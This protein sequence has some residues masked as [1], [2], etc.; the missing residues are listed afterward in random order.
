MATSCCS[1]QAL[2]RGKA[3]LGSASSGVRDCRG[4]RPSHLGTSQ[5]AKVFDGRREGESN[6]GQLCPASSGIGDRCKAVDRCL[7]SKDGIRRSAFR[8]GV[9][10]PGSGGV[11][12][13]DDG[14]F[15]RVIRCGVRRRRDLQ[16]AQDGKKEQA[17][18][19]YRFRRQ[20]RHAWGPDTT[21]PASGKFFEASSIQSNPIGK[22]VGKGSSG[23]RRRC[24][25]GQHFG[26]GESRTA[27]DVEGKEKRTCAT[28][29]GSFKC[30]RLR[31]I[32]IR[33]SGV[34]EDEGSR[35][36]LEGLSLWS[37]KDEEKTTET[38]TKVRARSGSSFGSDAT[39]SLSSFRLQSSSELGK[40]KKP[41]E[42]PLCCE[43]A[44]SSPFERWNREGG[45]DGRPTSSSHSSSLPRSRFMAGSVT[46]AIACG[47]PRTSQVRGGTRST[48]KDSIIH[49]G[50]ERSGEAKSE[51]G[52]R[53]SD[54]AS[55]RPGQRQGQEA[56]G[57]NRAIAD[58]SNACAAS[59][60]EEGQLLDIINRQHG[61]FSRFM[62]FFERPQCEAAGRTLSQPEDASV[63]M[64][65]SMLPWHRPPGKSRGRRG[66]RK[67]IRRVAF[68]WM[69]T[70]W[71]LFNFL[72]GGSPCTSHASQLVVERAQS[73]VWTAT[74]EEYARALFSK[75]V[76]YL[77]QPR[78]TL[79]RGTLGLN[80]LI[81]KISLSTYDPTIR[82]DENL[83]GAKTVDPSR[84][85]LPESA[86]ILDPKDHLTGKRLHDFNT[87]A[88][89]VPTDLPSSF[90]PKP[91]HKVSPKD[92]APLLKKLHQSGMIEF[93]PI[94]EVLHDGPKVIKGGLFCVAHKPTSDR[95]INDRRPLNARENRLG[96]C[97]LPAGHM[98][99][100]LILED[101][102]SVRCSG[103]D[104]SNY[105]Y[106]IK[107]L[108][109]W[110]H[111]N[112]FGDPILGKRL[113]HLGLQP[114]QKYLPAFR[115]VCMGDTNGVDIAQATHE[116][117]LAG[118][119]CLKPFQKLVYGEVFPASD[120]LEG[121]YID[122]HLIFQVVDKKKHRSRS[123]HEDEVLLKASR[124]R[125]KELGLP[126]SDKKAIN[127]PYDFKAW[128]TSVSSS[129]GRVGAPLEKLRQ[130]EYLA[131]QLLLEGH[132]SK[133][134]LQKLIG[135][136]VHPF[137]H[138]RECMS[139]FNHV[140]LFIENLPDHGIKRL[141]HHIRDEIAS[142]VLLLPFAQS[143][144]RTPVS[145]RLAATDA[146][147]RKGGRAS[148]LT[149]RA[150]AKTL[151]RFAE[152]KGEYGR[153]DWIK[154]SIAP[155]TCMKS[156]P[157]VLE[158][159]LNKHHWTA[160]HSMNFKK[161]EHINILEL[162]MVKQE[163]KDRANNHGGNVRVVNLCDSRVVV[164]C[165]AKGRSSSKNL[166]HRL[167]SCV[168][169]LLA[170]DVHLVNLWVSTHANPA[171]YPSRDKAIPPPLT[172]EDDEVLGK[173]LLHCVRSFR[174]VGEQCLLDREAR[175]N[176]SDPVYVKDTGEPP[177][178]V[179]SSK[180]VHRR[181]KAE[182]VPA[183]DSVT[184]AVDTSKV[185]ETVDQLGFREIF[186]GKGRLTSRM[187]LRG[188]F[189]VLEP[190]EY[191]KGKIKID[192]M[193]LLNDKVFKRLKKD[194]TL[195]LQLWHFGLPCS[196]FSLIQH[197]NGGTRRIHCPQGDGTLAREVEGNLLLARTLCLISI[198]ERHGN[199]W[200]LENPLTSYVWCMDS[201]KRKL[202]QENCFSV[203]FDQ[204]S[205]GLKLRDD[206]GDLGPCKKATRIVG[207]V[208]SLLNLQRKCSCKAKHIHAVGGVRTPQGWKR[209]SELAGHYP[210]QLCDAY[211]QA[212][213]SCNMTTQG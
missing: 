59:D 208:N 194:A 140:Y 202:E 171:D 162:E 191:M 44:A 165:F 6:T 34:Q 111:R 206:K 113:P 18:Q 212:I 42:N 11:K 205:Y 131:C 58:L 166:N 75:L 154:H 90:D 13:V 185:D 69:Q 52:S 54:S 84:I 114:N 38:C 156:A 118:A 181:E 5:G 29:Y 30:R 167:R 16:H 213:I 150:F 67:L 110:L 48:R 132:A 97:A 28:G 70:V 24:N 129:T 96:W 105:F 159:A 192:S 19:G 126:T 25:R 211:A 8:D 115:V 77:S 103:D 91:C 72:E 168:P 79:E 80:E 92:W 26:F 175:K 88:D 32:N 120:T 146:S 76:R 2:S 89:W 172:C 173:T 123:Q 151:Y 55:K 207:N 138:R 182:A 64:F 169:W 203:T 65:P 27:K 17:R 14:S 35:K 4:G 148:C 104:L 133:K 128:G 117:V 41:H 127:K 196:S 141:P 164:G 176:C 149:S 7:Q 73:G 155:P 143:N 107:H 20:A 1:A 200:T 195:P 135:C 112:C 144:I 180:R 193:N 86:A 93:V 83:S 9:R 125:Y 40:A 201:M 187:R 157:A 106:L 56:R 179:D 61:S 188:Q 74:H 50:H 71:G 124:E 47:P 94:D 43:R 78:G 85:S 63:T 68:R 15:E 152:T 145:V 189:R 134:A 62:S 153:L 186:A 99:G 109:S 161:K 81:S 60:L 130:I 121:L 197:S 12:E 102:Q 170:S 31:A 21:L 53:R 46:A 3:D 174:T 184:A 66:S 199:F 33:Q 39:V 210:I 116:A 163:I 82:L 22:A 36:G 45:F 147:S 95:L 57:G 101:H 37:P 51:C 136:F 10:R 183:R 119:G 142:A 209:R 100:Q 198:L 108:D 98:L 137:M 139:I 204:C 122:D 160:T 190:V 49:Q 178:Q 23:G 158:D 177:K 87:M